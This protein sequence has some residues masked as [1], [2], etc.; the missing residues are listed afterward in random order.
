MQHARSV[1]SST[2]TALPS[3]Y[4]SRNPT[5]GVD[6]CH[7]AVS[8]P[9]YAVVFDPYPLALSPGSGGDQGEARHESSPKEEWDML[10][11]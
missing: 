2:Y 5:E 8:V 7:I 3:P 6:M 11:M 9:L 1:H 4:Q 10:R